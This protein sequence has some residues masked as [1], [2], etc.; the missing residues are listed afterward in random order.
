MLYILYI[1]VMYMIVDR[2]KYRWYEMIV[3]LILFFGVL[4]V[5]MLGNFILSVLAVMVAP[6][7]YYLFKRW[8]RAED[9]RISMI[10]GKAARRALQ[11]F[12]I[13]VVIIALFFFYFKPTL[14]Y[15]TEI[16]EN[17]GPEDGFLPAWVDISPDGIIIQKMG[18][19][20]TITITENDITITENDNRWAVNNTFTESVGNLTSG[21]T[22]IF[23][24]LT[25]S[26]WAFKR[27]DVFGIAFLISVAAL[28]ILYAVFFDYYSWKYGEYGEKHEK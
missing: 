20:I 2:K 27:A 16:F 8:A 5:F 28:W 13:G 21:N 26:P 22:T 10:S 11:V 19:N 9:E 12:G 25:I 17:N 15:Y 24:E 6:I 4:I 14:F 7:I 23:S 3:L 1:E 18:N